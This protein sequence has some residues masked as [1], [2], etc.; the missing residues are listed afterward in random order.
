MGMACKDLKCGA[1]RTTSQ[2]LAKIHCFK[3]DIWWEC[4]MEIY[5]PDW[6]TAAE[7]DFIWQNVHSLFE[8]ILKQ[9]ILILN[10]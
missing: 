5:T 9:N 1:R 8:L 2:V 4:C 3:G 7:A 6:L 10:Y